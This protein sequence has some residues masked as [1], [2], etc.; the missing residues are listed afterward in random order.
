M[1]HSGHFVC[2]SRLAGLPLNVAGEFCAFI[3]VGFVL[4]CSNVTAIRSS[5]DQLIH[6]KYGADILRLVLMEKKKI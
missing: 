2:G 4:L 5:G 6:T 1:C 3:T